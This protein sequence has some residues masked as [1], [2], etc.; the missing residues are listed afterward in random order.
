LIATH[1]TEIIAEAETDD[2]LLI[3]KR[4]NSALRIRSDSQLQDVFSSLGSALN[5]VLTQLAK[6]RRVVFVEGKDFQI[7]GSFARKLRFDKVASRS[8][9]A[10]FPVEGFNP[11]RVRGLKLGMETAIGNK[12]LA[13]A[14]F[15]KD[16]RS[17]DECKSICEKCKSFC[18]YVTIYSRKEIENFLLVPNA[19]DRA[20]ERRIKDHAKRTEHKATYSSSCATLLDEFANQKK[21][22]VMAQYLDSRKRF[23]RSIS[24]GRSD[25]TIHEAVLVELEELWKDKEAR[26]AVIPGKDALSALNYHLQEKYGVNGTAAAIIDAMTVKDIPIE[27]KG[28]IQEIAAFS[29]LPIN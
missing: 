2:L 6:S 5:P 16:Y 10:V 19:L 20:C 1:S 27:M 18:D 28:L 24:S 25:A 12:I 3:N 17:G 13:A 4:K 29:L 9:F 22:Y 21:A 15:D 8:D 11:D 14:I 23:E 26:L 7:F